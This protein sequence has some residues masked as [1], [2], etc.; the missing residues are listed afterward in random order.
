MQESLTIITSMNWL[1]E[2]F[3]MLQVNY[4]IL[5]ERLRHQNQIIIRLLKRLK[6]Q[7]FLKPLNSKEYKHK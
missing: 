3:H 4:W 2:I 1:L 7:V 6:T 5:I